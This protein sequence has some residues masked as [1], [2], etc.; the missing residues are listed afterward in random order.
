[1]V[2]RRTTHRSPNVEIIRLLIVFKRDTAGQERFRSITSQFYRGANAVILIY[3]ITNGESFDHC[4]TWLRNIEEH[5]DTRVLKF[6]AGNKYDLNELRVVDHKKGLEVRA[7]VRYF[8][9]TVSKA[10]FGLLFK[11]ANRFGIEFFE[12][13]AKTGFNIDSLFNRVSEMLVELQRQQDPQGTAG[14]GANT[15]HVER[16]NAN[17]QEASFLSCC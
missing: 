10:T 15:V 11:Q 5:A 4:G 12:T 7:N 9:N 2:K 1:M 14:T 13:S 17:E 3:D 8:N 16:A 6:I